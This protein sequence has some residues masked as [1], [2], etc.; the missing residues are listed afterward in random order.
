VVR[1]VTPRPATAAA[2]NPLTTNCLN[3]VDKFLAALFD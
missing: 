2:H 3:V 1:T